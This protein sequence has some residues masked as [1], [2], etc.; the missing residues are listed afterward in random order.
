MKPEVR[1]NAMTNVLIKPHFSWPPVITDFIRK[2]KR[3]LCD[4]KFKDVA[5]AS[6]LHSAA[7]GG[8]VAGDVG[9]L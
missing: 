7:V 5:A 9:P 6:V 4:E 2:T 3:E 8:F 1:N